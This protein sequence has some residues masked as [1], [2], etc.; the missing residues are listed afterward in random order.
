MK[1][2][3]GILCPRNIALKTLILGS[4]GSSEKINETSRIS[5]LA[6]REFE[7]L[8]PAKIADYDTDNDGYI[9][10]VYLIYSAPYA[11]KDNN[12]IFLGFCGL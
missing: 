10:S 2:R 11:P 5:A 6:V 1:W 7:R 9:D 4:E 8:Y 3:R 12:N